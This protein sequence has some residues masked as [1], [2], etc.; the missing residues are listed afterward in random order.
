[1]PTLIRKVTRIEYHRNGISGVGFHLVEFIAREDRRP[2]LA[3][4]FHTPHC[5]AVLECDPARFLILG[6]R[7][8]GDLFEP[9][10]R[11]AIESHESKEVSAHV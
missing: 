2:M 4:V 9:E 3:A 7:W 11:A 5:V 1:M 8:R 10:L 6:S